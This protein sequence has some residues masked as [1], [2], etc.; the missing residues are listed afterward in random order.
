[1]HSRK[2]IKE[3]EQASWPLQRTKGSHHIFRHPDHKLPLP[4]P[5]P[6]KDLPA[7]TAS[8]LCG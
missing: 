6:K 4:E 8:G 7:G 1:M 3:L 5:R 2:L